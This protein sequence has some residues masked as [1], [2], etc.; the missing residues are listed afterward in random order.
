MRVEVFL[1]MKLETRVLEHW[2]DA[3][4]YTKDFIQTH[5]HMQMV[6]VEEIQ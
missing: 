5:A 4:V 1:V 6:R 2:H 3:K